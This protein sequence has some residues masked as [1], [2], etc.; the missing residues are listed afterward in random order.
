MAWWSK[1]DRRP[2]DVVERLSGKPLL[3]PRREQTTL[4]DR[5][6]VQRWLHELGDADRQVLVH[7]SW[8]TV[9]AVADG[10]H[11]VEVV[12]ADGESA[13]AAEPPGAESQRGL[14]PEQVTHVVLDALTSP[15]PPGWPAW[16]CLV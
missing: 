2:M 7:R 14:T 9:A 13:W 12:M 6:T 11:P 1:T 4:D 5:D 3:R 8:G 16:R 15:A 10:K